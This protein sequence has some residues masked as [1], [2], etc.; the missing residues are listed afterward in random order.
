MKVYVVSEIREDDFSNVNF[1]DSNYECLGVFNN[2]INAMS[3]V[4]S[5]LSF[6][7]DNN[8]G[9]NYILIKNEEDE[10]VFQI[11]YDDELQYQIVINEMEVK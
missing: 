6:Q 7:C 4:K 1:Y 11:N 8:G 3:F 5:E 9:W 10:I 2:E